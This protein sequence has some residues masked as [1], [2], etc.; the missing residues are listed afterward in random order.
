MLSDSQTMIAIA[1][2]VAAG[3][4]RILALMSPKRVQGLENIPVL[5]ETFTEIDIPVIPGCATVSEA[6]G[7]ALPVSASVPAA[8]GSWWVTPTTTSCTSA[9]RTPATGVQGAI[10]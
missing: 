5:A 4:L 9:A 8:A 1:P 6:I 2:H 10:F 7:L 3:K